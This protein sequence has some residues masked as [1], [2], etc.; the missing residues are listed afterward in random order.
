MDERYD[1]YILRAHVDVIIQPSLTRPLML[2]VG[3]QMPEW[4]RESYHIPKRVYP[5]SNPTQRSWTS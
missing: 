1:L 4:K 3:L 2:L 5:W